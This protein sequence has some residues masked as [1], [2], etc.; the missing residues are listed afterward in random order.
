[1]AAKQRPFFPPRI[2]TGSVPGFAPSHRHSVKRKLPDTGCFGIAATTAADPDS[3]FAN[4]ALVSLNAI[5]DMKEGEHDIDEYMPQL[6]TFFKCARLFSAE[7]KVTVKSIFALNL[8][9]RLNRDVYTCIM[10]VLANWT[11]SG[12][13][14]DMQTMDFPVSEGGQPGLSKPICM[15]K[16]LTYGINVWCGAQTADA[17]GFMIVKIPPSE[18]EDLGFMQVVPVYGPREQILRSCIWYAGVITNT[19]TTLGT[20]ERFAKQYEMIG[21]CL[22]PVEING[23]LRQDLQML[24][25]MTMACDSK[26]I[27]SNRAVQLLS[28]SSL[29]KKEA[30][31]RLQLITDAA[32]GFEGLDVIRGTVQ[33]QQ[34][35]PAAPPDQATSQPMIAGV[36]PPVTRQQ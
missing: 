22:F 17:A 20:P 14:T 16:G 30:A 9:L 21:R 10:D 26:Q 23:W 15:L 2:Q 18:E 25:K 8:H 24:D 4:C 28:P 36:A 19:S 12:I 1:M 34:A 33:R 11:Y 3:F 35:P 6:P 27:H 5:Q 32:L 7:S 29:I 31:T 13:M